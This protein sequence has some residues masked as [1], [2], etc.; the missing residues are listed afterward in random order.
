MII[1]QRP[2]TSPAKGGYLVNRLNLLKRQPTTRAKQLLKKADMTIVYSAVNAIQST[3]Y[4]LNPKIHRIMLP[5][6]D[7]GHLFFGLPAHT[8]GPPPPRLADD[9]DPQL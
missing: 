4:R 2:W 8:V 1:P 5:A 7:A 3:A 9:A 6:W